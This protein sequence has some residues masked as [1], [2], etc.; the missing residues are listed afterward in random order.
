MPNARKPAIT[1]LSKPHGIADDIVIPLIKKVTKGKTQKKVLNTAKKYADVRGETAGKKYDKAVKSKTQ[2]FLWN[3][4][5]V[6]PSLKGRKLNKQ[7][8]KNYQY[9]NLYNALSSGKST[10]GVMKKGKNQARGERHS[11]PRYKNK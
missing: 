11:N 1:G 10:K 4:P 6:G 9:A 5:Q 8:S 7:L 3:T 2:G